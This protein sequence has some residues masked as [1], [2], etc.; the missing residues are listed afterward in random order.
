MFKDYLP[1]EDHPDLPVW[2]SE[3]LMDVHATGCYTSQAAMKLFNRRNE[4]L[5]DAAERSAVIADWAGTSSYPKEFLTDAWKRFIWHQFHD[6]ITGTSIPRAY[7]FSWNDELISMKHFA[8]V[9][10]TS[11]GAFS[12][13]LDTQVKGTPVVVYNPVGNDNVG[14]VEISY[15]GMPENAVVYGPDG[16]RVPSQMSVRDGA[17]KLVFKASVAP[18]GYAVYDVRKSSVKVSASSALA[19]SEKGM[20]NSVYRLAFDANGD[21]CS[22]WDKRNDRELVEQG[23]AV[24][25]ALFTENKSYKWP[26]WEILK[27]TIDAD[28]VAVSE[29][30]KVNVVE[31]GPLRVTVCVERK[32]G[33]SVFKQYVSLTDGTLDDRIDI[34]NDVFWQ[35]T[36]A[37]LKAEFPL[38]VSNE[39]AVYDLGVGTIS[40][41]NNT[42]TSYEVYAQQWAEIAD[43]DGSYA[44]AVMN[45]I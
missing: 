7:E 13:L 27:E 12:R 4:L 39:K 26:A 15:D 35:T 25:L 24:R 38:S 16:R 36:D 31:E 44:V 43:T 11:V 34:V 6:D 20:E 29:D 37:L 45:D 33:D 40:R 14:L 3:L 10:T 28:P 5:A 32:W 30:V 41:G 18:V 42:M 9:L 23:K 21:I 17:R 2:K 19:V 1:Y 22:I 8:N